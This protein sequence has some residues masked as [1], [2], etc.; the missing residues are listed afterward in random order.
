ML[1]FDYD[2]GART[3]YLP[4]TDGDEDFPEDLAL[5]QARALTGAGY[6]PAWNISAGFE[7]PLDE[8]GH[9]NGGW[10][11]SGLAWRQS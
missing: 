1:F 3:T 2:E 7:G 6:G 5:L 4:L 8:V 10:R 9:R 11:H